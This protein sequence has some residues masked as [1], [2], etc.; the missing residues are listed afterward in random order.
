MQVF[1]YV[2]LNHRILL[3]RSVLALEQQEL[4]FRA[5]D[6][7]E[8]KAAD[9]TSTAKKAHGHTCRPC[10]WLSQQ[11]PFPQVFSTAGSSIDFLF[12]VLNQK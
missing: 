8:P 3:R 11:H 7:K 4:G 10:V 5:A 6:S 2:K 12:W 1:L 9:K